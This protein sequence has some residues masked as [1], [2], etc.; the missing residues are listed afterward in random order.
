[1]FNDLGEYTA[2]AHNSGMWVQTDAELGGD[3]RRQWFLR[4]S[5]D[6]SYVSYGAGAK[7]ALAF[8]RIDGAAIGSCSTTTRSF[9]RTGPTTTGPSPGLSSASTASW[10][11]RL[12]HEQRPPRR[13][14]PR[15]GPRQITSSGHRTSWPTAA[16]P[17]G[18]APNW[19]QDRRAWDISNGQLQSAW[20]MVVMPSVLLVVSV[21]SLLHKPTQRTAAMLSGTLTGIDAPPGHETTGSSP[22]LFPLGVRCMA[23]TPP[24]D[25]RTAPQ[26]DQATSHES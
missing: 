19:P 3:L 21:A 10:P 1:M 11:Y 18:G 26:P 17:L 8:L 25:P 4:T 13:R 16:W 24:P 23:A 20:P 7:E 9:P 22:T 5:Y 12:Q 6:W 15:R 14:L 2:D